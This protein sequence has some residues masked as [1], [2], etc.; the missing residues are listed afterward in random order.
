MNKSQSRYAPAPLSGSL[1]PVC[2]RR[3]Q[4]SPNKQP[5]GCLPAH[6]EPKRARVHL[7]EVFIGQALVLVLEQPEG[8]AYR[9]VIGYCSLLY[10]SRG[11]ARER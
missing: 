5:K 8:V 3:G 1:V 9:V 10:S 7:L 11:L 4:R 6:I 2:S